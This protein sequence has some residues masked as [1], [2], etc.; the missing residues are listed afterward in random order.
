MHV[1]KL[2]TELCPSKLLARSFNSDVTSTADAFKHW[3]T[4]MDNKTCKIV[5]IVGIVLAALVCFWI[6][7][8]LVSCIC[9][10]ISCI[11]ALCCC[12]CCKSRSGGRK[13]IVEKQEPYNNANMYPTAAPNYTR[14]PQPAYGG[15][16]YQPVGDSGVNHQ[17]PFHD[18]KHTSYRGHNF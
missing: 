3:D 17:N 5:A 9:L 12:C 15:G 4:C 8:T 10:G 6:I 11:E 14:Q 1:P 2:S 16:G 7:S 18:D 13:Q